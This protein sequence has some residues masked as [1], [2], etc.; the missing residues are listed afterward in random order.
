MSMILL[1]RSHHRAVT[2]FTYYSSNYHAYCRA[3]AGLD[4]IYFGRLT[5]T[6][7]DIKSTAA[8]TGRRMITDLPGITPE[9]W[10]KYE[11]SIRQVSTSD[12]GL[13]KKVPSNVEPVTNYLCYDQC[14]LDAVEIDKLSPEQAKER[15]R[16]QKDKFLQKTGLS[17]AEYEYCNRCLT[18]L[19]DYCARQQ[20]PQPLLAAWYKIKE[21]GMI[22]REN[23]LSTYMYAMSLDKTLA[24]SSAE[25]ASLHDLLY[26]PNEKTVTLRIK[27]LIAKGDAFGAEQILSSLPVRELSLS[28][29]PIYWQQ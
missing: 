26:D 10:S 20:A 9:L 8:T 17:L 16:E 6:P 21:C 14:L 7:I 12:R 22:P 25:V 28:Q 24:D 13:R 29:L 23:G 27:A 11:S 15:L 4:R 18:Y 2:A 5:A 19:G 3:T 1:P